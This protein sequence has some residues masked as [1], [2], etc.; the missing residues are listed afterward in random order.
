MYCSTGR[1]GILLW[2]VLAGLSSSVI[3]LPASHPIR[4]R[5]HRASR[6]AHAMQLVGTNLPLMAQ[7]DRRPCF[8]DFGP[9]AHRQTAS[10]TYPQ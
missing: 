10:F 7:L 3:M 4:H 1:C 2:L 9:T 5:A 8:F 6:A